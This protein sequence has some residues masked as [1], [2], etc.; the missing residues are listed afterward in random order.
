M[1]SA[2]TMNPGATVLTLG[3]GA[4]SLFAIQFAQASGYRVIATTSSQAKMDRLH[5]MGVPISSTTKSTQTG[6]KKF[7]D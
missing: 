7:Y 2:P 5:S 4:V 3:T 6:S 1:E